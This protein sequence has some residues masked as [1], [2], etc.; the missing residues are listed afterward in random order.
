MVVRMV[1][2]KERTFYSVEL[3]E[4]VSTAESVLNFGKG[5]KEK[6]IADI[7]EYTLP[8]N[9]EIAYDRITLNT[10]KYDLMSKVTYEA[11]LINVH[12]PLKDSNKTASTKLM[13]RKED[14]DIYEAQTHLTTVTSLGDWETFAP[15]T[16]RSL[17]DPS[18]DIMRIVTS[19]RE[20]TNVGGGFNTSGMKQTTAKM[21]SNTQ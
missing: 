18:K 2:L 10:K 17:V 19:P 14:D 16:E 11:M 15:N 13:Q 20:G 21:Y 12:K 7:T 3:F 9:R 6:G 8:R 1:G 5:G 4:E